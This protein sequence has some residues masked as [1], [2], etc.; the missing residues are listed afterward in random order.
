MDLFGETAA[1][2]VGTKVLVKLP[3]G[4]IGDAEFHGTNECYRDRLR[5]W[6]G[7]FFPP[8]YINFLGMNPSGAAAAV[9]DRTIAR[10]WFFTEREGFRGFS[11]TNIADYRHKDPATLLN[12]QTPVCSDRN[13]NTIL[14][15]AAGA[16]KIVVGF[17]SVN[18][19]LLPHAQRAIRSL[20]ADGRK[21]WCF[22]VNADGSPKH[23]L[24]VA[25]KTEL[26]VWDAVA[27]LN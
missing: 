27:W 5:R 4:V 14:Y 17:G 10:E 18:K 13:L 9:N 6:R 23:P 15:E 21:L 24:Y 1:H 2:D 7:E 19:A 12:L 20:V 8:V 16:A 11:K 26:K 3:P 22:D 25:G